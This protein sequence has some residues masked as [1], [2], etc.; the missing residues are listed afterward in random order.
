MADAVPGMAPAALSVPSKCDA[1]V[2]DAQV[3]RK[4]LMG[5]TRTS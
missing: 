1:Q 2:C 5:G 3:F 4:G